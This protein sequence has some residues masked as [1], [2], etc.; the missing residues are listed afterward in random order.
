MIKEVDFLVIGGGPAGLAASLVAI[1]FGVH[2]V[3]LD[4]GLKLG[5]QLTKQT[6]K[7]FGSQLERAGTRGFV[8]GEEMVEELEVSNKFEFFSNTTAAGFY[9]DG[10]ITAVKSENEWLKFKPKATL[11]ATGASERMIAFPGND[12]PG[13]YGAGAV[14]TLMNLYGVLPGERVLMIGAGNIGLIVSYQLMQAG[15]RV[16][17]IVEAMDKI[18]G[19]WVHASKIARL[20][21]PILTR[22]T[23]VEARGADS[24][25]SAIIA[26]VDE[27]WQIVP[28]TEVEV[29]IDTICLAVGLSPTLELL[30]QAGADMKYVPEFG[31]NVPLRDEFMRTSIKNAFVAGDAA[32]IEEA[33][34]AMIEGSIAGLAAA[35]HIGADIPDFDDRINKL[36]GELRILRA[37]PLPTKLREGL[38]KVIVKW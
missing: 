10:I 36:K 22:Y 19:Y 1:E 15:V 23:I 37:G 7:F 14:Q 6:H 33:S 9:P 38:K 29:N 12:L 32:G 17:A 18:G 25:D 20:G 3:I 16:A 21:V 27:N 2:T 4:D 26:K 31:G 30:F 24:V 35:R 8:I 11:L 13:V 34:S 5:G 28:G